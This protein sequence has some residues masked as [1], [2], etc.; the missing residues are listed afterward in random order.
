MAI[1][2]SERTR[3]GHIASECDLRFKFRSAAWSPPRDTVSALRTTLEFI[4]I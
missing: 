4:V 3:S 1:Q 2:R